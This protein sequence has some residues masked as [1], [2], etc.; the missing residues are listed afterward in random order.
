MDDMTTTTTLEAPTATR[1]PAVQWLRR[2]GC[3]AQADPW[4][5]P[6]EQHSQRDRDAPTAI[7][8]ACSRHLTTSGEPDTCECRMADCGHCMRVPGPLAHAPNHA[9][10]LALVRPE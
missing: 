1:R 6:F 4:A 8:R 9:D 2:C 7:V 3:T 10:P 5:A